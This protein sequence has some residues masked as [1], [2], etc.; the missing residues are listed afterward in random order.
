[1]VSILETILAH[2]ILLSIPILDRVAGGDLKLPYKKL[3]RRIGIPLVIFISFPSINVALTMIL[4]GIVL[5]FNLDEIEEKD[6][7]DVFCYGLALS[8]CL[9][10]VSGIYSILVAFTWLVGVLLSNKWNRVDWKYVEIARGASIA[11]SVI[12]F[13]SLK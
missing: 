9:F 3:L 12:I 8:A 7:D 13:Q 1:M 10:L 2:P 5:S 4:M 11:L 6:W